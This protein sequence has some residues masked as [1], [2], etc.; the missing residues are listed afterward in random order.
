[1]C[2]YETTPDGHFLIGL[3]PGFDNVW[4]VG[5][6]SGHGFKHGPQLGRYAVSRIDGVA[7]GAQYGPDE[8]RFRVGPRQSQDAAGTGRDIMARAW[9]LF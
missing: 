2:Q 4:I 7:E 3:L 1:V 8:E 5:G 6:G 9:E